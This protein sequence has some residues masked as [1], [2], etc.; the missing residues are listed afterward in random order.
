VFAA[1]LV[2]LNRYSS[3]QK[4]IKLLVAVMAVSV[5][6]CALLAAPPAA[7][8]VKGLFVPLLPA[9][10]GG[11]AVLALLGG[12]G[13][14][15]TVIC[16][17]YWLRAEGWSGA[18][19]LSVVRGDVRFAYVFTGIFGIALCLI[20][21]GVHAQ[22]ASGARIAL[23]IAARLGDVA[24]PIPRGLFLIGFWA[25]VFTAM[26]GVWQGVPHI[27]EDL[28]AAWRGSPPATPNRPLYLGALVFLA[29]PPLF[30][31][32]HR[33]P[34]AIVLTFSIAGAFFMPFL[35]ATLLYLN[36][37]RAW[38]GNL[39]NGRLGNAALVLCLLVFGVVC[40]R[41]VIAALG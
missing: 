1:L 8:V 22:A 30:F 41:E 18:E 36:N 11:A 2:A 20:A 16:Y 14:S 5:V 19:K 12:I 7:D 32:W 39:A 29:G 28:Y 3:F 4:L 27:Y 35:A 23:E 21:A 10:G 40:A 26:L 38:V 17:S 6:V 37:R 9:T 34:V 13:G 15:V 33:Q 25:T 31:L 24:G